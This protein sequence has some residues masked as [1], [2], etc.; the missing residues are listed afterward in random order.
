MLAHGR[1]PAD[2]WLQIEAIAISIV[3]DGFAKMDPDIRVASIPRKD[4]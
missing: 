4:R 1:S 2:E 3:N